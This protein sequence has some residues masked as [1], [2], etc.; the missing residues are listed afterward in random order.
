MLRNILRFKK[1]KRQFSHFS[2]VLFF[3]LI[4]VKEN[5]KCHRLEAA[6][7][8]RSSVFLDSEKGSYHRGRL[9]GKDRRNT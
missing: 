3:F 5:E 9:V 7:G 6:N 4:H 1:K 2:S 8:S